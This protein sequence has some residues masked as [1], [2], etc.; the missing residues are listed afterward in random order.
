MSSR[1]AHTAAKS[2]QQRYYTVE[3]A[4][5]V[6][7][8]ISDLSFSYNNRYLAISSW[9]G[10][11]NVI[12]FSEDYGQ[13]KSKF[14]RYMS[15]TTSSTY[16]MGTG[17]KIACIRCLFR[18]IDDVLY[19]T[20]SMGEIY[21]LDL[22]PATPNPTKV[23]G[24]PANEPRRGPFVGLKWNESAQVF[25]ALEITT[26]GTNAQNLGG[27]LFT[28]A[29]ES[30]HRIDLDYKPIA[31]DV[32]DKY[33]IVV[34]TKYGENCIWCY[35]LDGHI[36][37]ETVKVEIKSQLKHQFT[38]I[39]CGPIL[40]NT[41]RPSYIASTVFG[42]ADY[43]EGTENHDIINLHI[44]ATSK[45]SFGSNSIAF[46]P[47]HKCAVSA[48]SDGTITFVNLETKRTK[49]FQISQQIPLTKL[50]VHPNGNVIAIASGYDWSLGYEM[51]G[52]EK[53]PINLYIRQFN[54]SDYR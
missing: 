6:K 8:D 24:E 50:A 1:Y 25:V 28:L 52:R 4:F 43:N 35:T 22:A 45:A 20:T 44:N 47:G 42:Q 36:K 11:I 7:D 31:L 10:S 2:T 46:V 51:A 19:F 53:P 23:Y 9:D 30:S 33:V 5:N 3:N 21:S 18:P 26:A 37:N 27:S 32:S 40:A 15:T 14:S 48:S 54:P 29:Q 12:E 41:T 34:G 16:T 17:T 39:A 38:S 49:A 13:A